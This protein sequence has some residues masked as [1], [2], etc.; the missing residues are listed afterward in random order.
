MRSLIVGALVVLALL[1]QQTQSLSNA[2]M[3]KKGMFGRVNGELDPKAPVVVFMHLEKCGGTT[4]EGFFG[5]VCGSRFG[6]TRW[7]LHNGIVYSPGHLQ[8]N[9]LPMSAYEATKEDDFWADRISLKQC[10]AGHFLADLPRL[11]AH[12][13]YRG[14][15]GV[16]AT[17]TMLRE[18]K[19]RLASLYSF[20]LFQFARDTGKDFADFVT[21]QTLKDHH[22]RDNYYVRVFCP[23]VM[24][25]GIGQV[26][27]GDVQ[28]ALAGMEQ[29]SLVLLL[30]QYD[31]SLRLLAHEMS[32]PWPK[33]KSLHRQKSSVSLWDECGDDGKP[34]QGDRLATALRLV[35]HDNVMYARA[36]ELLQEKL[37]ATVFLENETGGVSG[38]ITL[39]T[40]PIATDGVEPGLRA[41]LAHGKGVFVPESESEMRK[42]AV[43]QLVCAGSKDHRCQ[44]AH[45]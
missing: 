16:Y 43:V 40:F 29:M 7:A 39:R 12:E 26:T 17:V 21:S 33:R 34:L 3:I 18:P 37:A 22:H 1:A 27:E 41:M 35:T 45:N 23:N 11:F 32:L 19:A 10:I 31:V 6:N 38:N 4:L 42:N 8:L 15:H 13:A 9:W 36:V 14:S 44:G 25:K 5:H 2:P 28:C 24:L 30:E 20:W